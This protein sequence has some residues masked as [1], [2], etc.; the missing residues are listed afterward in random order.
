MFLPNS[1]EIRCGIT[2]RYLLSFHNVLFAGI[3]DDIK[4]NKSQ[5]L[6]RHVDTPHL[7]TDITDGRIY[8]E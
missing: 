3:W 7:I 2:C 4:Q 1:K 6:E 5:I 8:R